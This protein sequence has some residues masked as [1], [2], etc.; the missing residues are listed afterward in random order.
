MLSTSKLKVFA[1]RGP[2]AFAAKYITRKHAEE[3]DSDAL[4]VGQIL[5]DAVQGR[6]FDKAAYW[7]KPDGFKFNS[8]ANKAIRDEQL[9]LGK[10]IVSEADLAMIELMRESVVSNETALDMIRGC[11]K[12]AT[13]RMPYGSTPGL[14][15]RPDWSSKFGCAASG[16]EPYSVDL[17][18]TRSL[19]KMLSGRGVL[20]YRYDAQGALV[21]EGMRAA[22]DAEIT[23]HFLLCVEKAAPFRAVVVELDAA[24][25][26]VGWRWCSRQLG[27]LER[28]YATCD[29]PRVTA[30]LVRLPAPPAWADADNSFDDDEEA[31]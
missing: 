6:A 5:E 15:S 27:K 12:Q 16:F 10:R 1:D 24:W 9:A 31:A 13:I 29:W 20:E 19:G 11:D 18:S 14:Q 30:E 17:K 28:H 23:R 8:A 22:L 21:R 7:V 26:D 2:R 4:I 25:L 3:A